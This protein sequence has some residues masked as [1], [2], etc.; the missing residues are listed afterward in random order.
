MPGNCTSTRRPVSRRPCT[1]ASTTL[2]LGMTT[3]SS[4]P[5]AASARGR[6]PITSPKP[7]VLTYGAASEATK[8]IFTAS[9]LRLPQEGRG[10]LGGRGIDVAPARPFEPGVEGEDRLQFQVPVIPVVAGLAQRQRVQEQV[11]GRFFQGDVHLA[12]QGA[13]RV[14]GL[15][16]ELAAGGLERRLVIARKE[17]DLER[18]A[19]G[20]GRN[21]HHPVSLEDDALLVAQF[22][23]EHVAP[24][25][26]LLLVEMALRADELVLQRGRHE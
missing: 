11:V 16:D 24:D 4:C 22:L 13:Q 2:Y 20:P 23:R 7:P 5:R 12:Q 3:R 19:R 6:A 1:C 18:R 14:G 25:A 10:L 17:Q 8:R 9:N 21:G 15:A 26:A